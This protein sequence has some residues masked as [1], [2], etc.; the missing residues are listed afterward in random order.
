MITLELPPYGPCGV[1][2]EECAKACPL[3]AAFRR[4]EQAYREILDRVR[5]SDIVASVEADSTVDHLQAVLRWLEGNVTSLPRG[6]MLL[7]AAYW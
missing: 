3:A 1:K 6:V 7:I 2:R 5:L 4:A